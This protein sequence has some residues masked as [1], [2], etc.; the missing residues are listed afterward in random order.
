MGGPGIVAPSTEWWSSSGGSQAPRELPGSALRSLVMF[1]DYGSSME[2]KKAGRG[3]DGI[4]RRPWYCFLNGSEDPK[5]ADVKSHGL[6]AYHALWILDSVKLGRALPMEQ[7]QIDERL[8]P[9]LDIVLQSPKRRSK[10]HKLDPSMQSSPYTIGSS[11]REMSMDLSLAGVMSI[12]QDAELDG[13]FQS[14]SRLSDLRDSSSV[15][16]GDVA[17]SVTFEFDEDEED[18]SRVEILIDMEDLCDSNNALEWTEMA[19]NSSHQTPTPFNQAATTPLELDASLTTSRLSSLYPHVFEGSTLFLPQKE[20]KG[21]IFT[22]TRRRQ[23][24][25]TSQNT[26]S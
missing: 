11:D 12:D 19:T 8:H 13:V 18:K 17:T 10:P 2:G 22:A 14:S 24:T 25:N 5:L 15:L 6:V 4:R 20:Y 26:T 16:S 3:K 7:Y 23:S 9:A 1:G 21:K